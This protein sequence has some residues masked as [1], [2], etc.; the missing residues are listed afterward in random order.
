MKKVILVDGNDNEIGMEEKIKAH[1]RAMLHRALSIFVFNDKNELMLQ[2]RADSKYHSPG[3]WSNTACSHPE[4]GETTLSAAHK[5]LE[6]EMGFDCTLTEIFTF[7]YKAKFANGLTENEVDHVFIGYF[8]SSPVINPSEAA[9]WRWASINEIKKD[10]HKKP[11]NYTP[12]FKI[13]FERVAG[14]VLNKE[15]N[16]GNS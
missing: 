8:N 14:A 15:A 16:K 5:R 10:L 12:W 11:E 2:K 7:A 13:I 4:P 3:L 1:A 6:E 9:A